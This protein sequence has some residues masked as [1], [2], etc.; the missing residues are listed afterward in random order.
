MQK[1]N[2]LIA[3]LSALVAV[4]LV[5][6]TA[7]TV[8][9]L[10]KDG[11]GSSSSSGGDKTASSSVSDGNKTASAP[12]GGSMTVALP[13]DVKLELVKVEAG[14]FEM[15]AK[16]GENFGDEVPHRVTLTK[17]FYLGKTEVTQAQWKAVMGNDPSYFKGD[18][19]P[20]ESVSWY[21][22]MAFCEKLNEMGKAPKGYK[23]TLP[24]ETQWEYAARG[25]RKS[26][27]YKYSGSD[28]I[29]EVAWYYENSG[30]RRLDERELL[31]DFT[32]DKLVKNLKDNNC[33]THPVAGKKANELG[34]YDMSG[35]VWEW[36]LDDYNSDS[37]K[38][39]PE[40]ARSADDSRGSERVTRGG[41]WNFGARFCRS[42]GRGRGGPGAR[43]IDV[44]FR[45]ALVPVQ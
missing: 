35:N 18:A 24:T 32:V 42:A 31:K 38:A 12:S 25:G 3:G 1:K 5:A 15:S 40:F 4:L 16:D 39:V 21:D 41:R 14:S 19:L 27:G 37:S 23:F 28:N 33:Q 29:G 34:L 30:D 43:V 45:L 26:R 44:G 10:M 2:W 9:L 8:V 6:V 13:G 22:A 20:V 17:D 36:C 11:G 7:L